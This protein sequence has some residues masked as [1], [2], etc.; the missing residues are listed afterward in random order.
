MARP[1]EFEEATALNAATRRFWRDGFAA[2]SVRVLAADMRIAGASLYIAFGSKRAL[3]DR[4]IARHA[5][6]SRIAWLKESL[7]PKEAVRA[8]LGEIVAHWLADHERRGCLLVNSA[9]EAAPKDAAIAAEIAALLGEIEAFFRRAVARAGSARCRRRGMPRISP[10]C[11]GPSRSVSGCWRGRTRS[12]SCSK[13]RCDPLS[14]CSTGHDLL[15]FIN[16]AEGVAMTRLNDLPAAMAK[17]LAELE[18]PDFA[19]TPW[20]EG[21]PLARRRVAIVSSAGLVVRGEGPFRGR[22]ADYRVI[23]SATSSDRLLMSHISINYDRTGFLEDWNV[24]FPL[25]R[26]PELVAEGEI[27]SVGATHYSF[28]GATDPVQMEGYAREVA[29]HLKRD[30]VDAVLLS[31]V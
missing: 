21:P 20:V 24:V 18:C 23:P 8:F 17:R 7:P 22:D 10:G 1:R 15:P 14:H 13:A 12:A 11:Y 26:L 16:I 3:F 25:D 28:M 29:G 19:T 30:Q 31:P 5:A 2:V 27:G 6:Q 4:A 9:V